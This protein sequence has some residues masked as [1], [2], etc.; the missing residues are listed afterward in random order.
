M[1]VDRD[2]PQKLYSQIYD[3]LK[4]KI[5]ND[6][7]PVQSQIPT[8]ESLCTEYGV[9]KATIRLA[10]SELA[11]QGYL[12]RIQG[13]GTFVSRKAVPEGLRL[14]SS[15]RDFMLEAGINF[16]TRVLAQTVMMPTDDLD[17][18]LNVTMEQ[19]LIYIK[20]LRSV[21]DEPVLLQETFIPRHICP[22]ML[23]EDVA[24]DSMI[25]VLEK[26]HGVTIT[27]VKDYFDITY[28]NAEES[29]IFGLHEGSA[30]LLL[31]QLF[32]SGDTRIMYTRSVK[33]PDRF[34]LYLELDR[35]PA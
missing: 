23:Q 17:R 28:L 20:R 8:E 25:D 34:K 9:S 24:N 30:S 22:P 31:T 32:F 35:K 27:K 29:G 26:K 6:A 14:L 2:K 7:W 33:R 10:L 21:D 3:I 13:K 19:H 16:T 5:E 1:L 12:K 11:R 4:K 18:K 15:F